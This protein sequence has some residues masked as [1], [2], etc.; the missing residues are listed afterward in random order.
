VEVLYD[1]HNDLALKSWSSCRAHDL[2]NIFHWEK[3]KRALRWG[4]LGRGR[5]RGERTNSSFAMSGTMETEV[6]SEGISSPVYVTRVNLPSYFQGPLCARDKPDL[7]HN[8]ARRLTAVL[9]LVSRLL[10][11]S[12]FMKPPSEDARSIAP[13]S[14]PSSRSTAFGKKKQRERGREREREN[15]GMKANVH[16]IL[17][18][19]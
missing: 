17:S 1:L 16:C 14:A 18:I 7:H 12:V 11:R 4:R 9:S 10:S 5:Y 8:R 2:I 15:F 13:S 3:V 19:Q 6:E